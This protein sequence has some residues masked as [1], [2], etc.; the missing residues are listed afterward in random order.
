MTLASRRRSILSRQKAAEKRHEQHGPSQRRGNKAQQE[1]RVRYL[2]HHPGTE[3]NAH[4]PGH[5][6]AGAA[7]PED[8]EV[9]YF[10]SGH[11]AADTANRSCFY[12]SR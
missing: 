3:E 9:A 12:F 11:R 5:V 1:G 2:P 6:G 8:A 4:L 10:E 7:G